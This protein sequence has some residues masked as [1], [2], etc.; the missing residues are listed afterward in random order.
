MPAVLLLTRDRSVEQLVGDSLRH[1]GYEVVSASSADQALR[2]TLSI[3]VG[4]LVVDTAVGFDEVE[5]VSDWVR[6]REEDVPGIVFLMSIRTRPASLPIDAERDELVAK[7]FTPE[8]VR[9]AVERAGTATERSR[10]DVLQVGHTE[11]D[12][13][14][15]GIRE[16]GAAVT[17]SPTEFRLVEYLAQQGGRW[18]SANEL[19][20]KVWE[21]AA[22]RRSAA[23]IRTHVQNLRQKLAPL[24]NGREF[25]QSWPRRGYRLR[26]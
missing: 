11:L 16:E 6:S 12:R 20:E 7:P 4:S 18:V 22:D 17:V 21:R 9:L 14:S 10:P 15:L 25:I 26:N 2:A 23:T 5:A 8:Q 19:A 1:A 13:R 3:R 24:P